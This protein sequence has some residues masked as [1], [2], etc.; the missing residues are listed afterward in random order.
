[1]RVAKRMK[2]RRASLADSPSAGAVAAAAAMRRF[3]A[4]LSDSDVERIARAIDDN[5]GAGA[6]LHQK[7]NRLRNADDL[8][9]TFEADPQ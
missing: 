3:D 1:M 2:D 6:S 8:V 5:A 9:L 7:K 4:A